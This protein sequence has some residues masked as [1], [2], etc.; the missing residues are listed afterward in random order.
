MKPAGES[1]G[2]LITGCNTAQMSLARE[3]MP[4]MRYWCEQ[5]DWVFNFSTCPQDFP[6]HP[7]F[8]KWEMG[9]QF[10]HMAP[11]VLWLDVDV[12][13]INPARPLELPDEVRIAFSSALD[14]PCAG[15]WLARGGKWLEDFC[16]MLLFMGPM[17]PPDR[18]QDQTAMRYITGWSGFEG[19]I[20]ALGRDIISDQDVH[21]FQSVQPLFHHLWSNQGLERT[22]ERIRRHAFKLPAQDPMPCAHIKP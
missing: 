9:R 7:Y 22:L 10:A 19:M 6:R 14:G 12:I 20:G 21:D 13:L 11:L 4:G 17:N 1:K 3:T 5:N 2:I 16:R 8:W 15:A 18:N